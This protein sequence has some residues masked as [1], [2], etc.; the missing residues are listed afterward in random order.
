MKVT[1][2]G[3]R[4]GLQIKEPFFSLL[5]ISSSIALD[6]FFFYGGFEEDFSLIENLGK[7]GLEVHL[8]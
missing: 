5:S 2:V 8:S 3:R 6:I 1:S 7:L 4:H